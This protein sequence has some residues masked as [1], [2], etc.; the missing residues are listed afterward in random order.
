MSSA[1]Q[2]N[3]RALS[4]LLCYTISKHYVLS[5]ICSSKTSHGLLLDSF[6][7]NVCVLSKTSSHP[8]ASAKPPLMRQLPEN[9]TWHNIL[10]KETRHSHFNWQSAF[11]PAYCG[12][13]TCFLDLWG[14]HWRFVSKDY[15]VTVNLNWAKLPEDI[16]FKYMPENFLKMPEESF[17][18]CRG[19]WQHVLAIYLLYVTA[20]HSTP[21][22]QHYKTEL[23]V[24]FQ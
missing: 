2:T 20:C 3:A 21:W 12:R 15:F 10:S 6:Q 17:E 1:R 7:R 9:I 18:C 11:V 22:W 14:I 24:L 19:N 23:N 4:T 16:F 13:S 8:S 5:S